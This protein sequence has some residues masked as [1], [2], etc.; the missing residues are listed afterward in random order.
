[1]YDIDLSEAELTG[2]SASGMPKMLKITIEKCDPKNLEVKCEPQEVINKAFS[3]YYC[4]IF[5]FETYLDLNDIDDPIKQKITPLTRYD[6]GYRTIYAEL[7]L[8]SYDFTDS[9]VN[10]M[11]NYGFKSGRSGQFFSTEFIGSN[12]N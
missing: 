4:G 3:E 8:N 6:L 11:W 12:F 10:S 7:S 5:A 1:M 9:T 2:S